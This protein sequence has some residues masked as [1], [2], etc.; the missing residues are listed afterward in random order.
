VRRLNNSLTP[1]QN[2]GR[3]VYDAPNSDGNASCNDCHVLDE[4]NGF[5]GT[6][7]GQSFE[8]EPQ[9]MKVP[10]L[11]NAYAK[12]GM[13]GMFVEPDLSLGAALGPQVRGFGF[14]HDG[15]VDT[16]R[17]FLSA[18]VFSTDGTEE[19]QLEQFILAFPTDLAPAVGQQATLDASNLAAVGGRIFGNFEARAGAPF[20]SFV[21][22][23][24]VTQCDLVVRGQVAGAPRGWLYDPGTG[25][26]VDDLGNA[27]DGAGLQALAASSGPLTFTCA[28]P[29]SGVRMAHNRDR[30][31]WNDGADN[32]PGAHNDTQLDT[33]GDQAGD[34]CDQDDDGDALLDAYETGTGTFGGAFDTGTDPL[35]ADTDG[36]GID[37]GVEVAQQT[38][39]TDANDPLP[40]PAP[41]L[42]VAGLLML[43]VALVGAAARSR[44]EH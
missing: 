13:F 12:V 32:C 11:R 21:L 39:P 5:F 38:D 42:P 40:S 16:I 29:G 4:A 35:L 3:L 8:G 6:G 23:G 24:S 41:A 43:G 15:V 44:R 36:D 20:E 1:V 31:A 17:N 33:D 30:D 25:Q 10:H 34:A 2:A 18:V 22:G 28:P 14:L 19:S 26:Y 37:D 9:N 7:G 27:T